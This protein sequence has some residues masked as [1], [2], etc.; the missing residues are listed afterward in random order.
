MTKPRRAAAVKHLVFITKT[1]NS[2]HITRYV[3]ACGASG[4]TS[5]DYAANLTANGRQ[6]VTCPVCIASIHIKKG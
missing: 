6:V 1:E 2:G 3:A 5:R 4:T